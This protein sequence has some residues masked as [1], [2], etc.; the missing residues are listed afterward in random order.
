[1]KTDDLFV[2]CP[3][4]EEK[5]ERIDCCKPGYLVDSMWEGFDLVKHVATEASSQ[6]K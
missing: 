5:V 1:M 2:V 4:K 6:K 3:K